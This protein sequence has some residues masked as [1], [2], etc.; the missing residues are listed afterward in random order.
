MPTTH[1]R[2]ARSRSPPVRVAR[3]T[4]FRRS[5]CGPRPGGHP[6]RV[7]ESCPR[8]S[9]APHPIPNRDRRWCRCNR[10]GAAATRYRARP[11]LP[12]SRRLSPARGGT[13]RPRSPRSV[14]SPGLPSR[15]VNLRPPAPRSPSAPLLPGDLEWSTCRTSCTADPTRRK[16]PG[17]GLRP[18]G[19]WEATANGARMGWSPTTRATARCS[20]IER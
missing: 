5:R 6:D 16:A 17:S 3:P 2:G 18:V 9:G 7:S 1:G 11:Q 4:Q 19:I 14:P 15:W 20:A 8:T 13:R 12:C 10:P